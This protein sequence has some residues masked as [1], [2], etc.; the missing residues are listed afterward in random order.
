MIKLFD[1]EVILDVVM[2]SLSP[3]YSSINIFEN[4]IYNKIILI[5]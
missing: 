4:K 5:I 2:T 3:F 1:K